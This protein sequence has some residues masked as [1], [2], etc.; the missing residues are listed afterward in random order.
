MVRSRAL[1]NQT[2]LILLWRLGIIYTYDTK[3]FKIIDLSG[4]TSPTAM[5]CQE[6]SRGPFTGNTLLRLPRS[7]VINL[8]HIR[9]YLHLITQG[10][11]GIP[12]E[13]NGKFSF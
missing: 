13:G 5:T 2:I 9:E 10:G 11:D 3:R 1:N 12:A 7:A 4:I 8:S 6:I